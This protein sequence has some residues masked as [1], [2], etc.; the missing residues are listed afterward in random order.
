LRTAARKDSP[1]SFHIRPTAAP[2]MITTPIA[3]KNDTSAKMIPIGPYF[4]S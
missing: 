2:K 4:W 1:R 3:M